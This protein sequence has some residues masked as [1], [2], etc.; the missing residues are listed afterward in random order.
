MWHIENPLK[1]F[2]DN[3]QL[4][5]EKSFTLY[6]IIPQDKYISFPE[7]DRLGLEQ[8]TKTGFSIQDIQVR[9]PNNPAQFLNAKLVSYAE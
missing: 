2:Q 1:V 7:A 6:A 9:N 3:L 8:L 4:Q 5:N